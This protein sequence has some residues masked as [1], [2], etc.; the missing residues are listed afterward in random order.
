MSPS[1]VVENSG[2]TLSSQ[3]ISLASADLFENTQEPLYHQHQIGKAGFSF[4]GL[5]VGEDIIPQFLFLAMQGYPRH[6][7]KKRVMLSSASFCLV[8]EQERIEELNQGLVS[9]VL[10]PEVVCSVDRSISGFVL[11]FTMQAIS[12]W[13]LPLGPYPELYSLLGI[14]N[15]DVQDSCIS[16]ATCQA[17]EAL[18]CRDRQQAIRGMI[19][20]GDLLLMPDLRL[21]MGM[22]DNM[23][24]HWEKLCNKIGS[25]QALLPQ[26]YHYISN[27]MVDCVVL[28]CM[29][30]LDYGLWRVDSNYLMIPIHFVKFSQQPIAVCHLYLQVVTFL[31][32]KGCQF[33]FLS[34]FNQQKSGQQPVVNPK[35]QQGSGSSSSE[36]EESDPKY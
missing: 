2:V 14:T 4:L 17:W 7:L 30:S 29:Y 22:F 36:Q 27:F 12:S 34:L 26:E 3:P 16:R 24:A 5:F 32:A 15:S 9:I 21:P 1:P 8:S 19:L 6:D 18:H 35:S 31:F 10:D 25:I 13:F 11:E 20:C 33:P 23:V 28:A